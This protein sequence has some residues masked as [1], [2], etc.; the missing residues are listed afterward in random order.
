MKHFSFKERNMLKLTQLD[1][2]C[3]FISSRY[4]HTLTDHQNLTFIS[5]RMKR[6]GQNFIIIQ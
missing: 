3:L 1:N 5:K 2:Y 4:L 6:N